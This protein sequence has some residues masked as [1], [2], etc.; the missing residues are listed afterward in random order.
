MA[1][2]KD[3]RDTV[4]ARVKRDPVFRGELII[5]ATNALLERECFESPFEVK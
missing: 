2:T 5:E 1:L 3:F 4:M